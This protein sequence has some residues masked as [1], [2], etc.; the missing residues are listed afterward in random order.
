VR[1]SR[2]GRRTSATPAE[3]QRSGPRAALVAGAPG[4]GGGRS[5]AL[6]AGQR[7]ELLDLQAAREEG[8]IRLGE[9]AVAEGYLTEEQLAEALDRRRADVPLPRR[10]ED[11]D[12]PME[13]VAVR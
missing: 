1:S 3:R 7:R 8:W 12:V 5:G 10:T 2:G 13:A 11:D 6:T 9:L 4:G